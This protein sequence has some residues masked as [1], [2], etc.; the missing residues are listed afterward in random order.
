MVMYLLLNVCDLVS[1]YH[2]P[3]F[4]TALHDYYSVLILH[5]NQ[6][7]WVCDK[8]AGQSMAGSYLSQKLK[9]LHFPS[10]SEIECWRYS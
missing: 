4:C 8:P 1:L 3:D 7:R 6:Q 5:H 9:E 10:H 2:Y